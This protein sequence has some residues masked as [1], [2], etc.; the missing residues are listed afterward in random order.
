METTTPTRSEDAVLLE[1]FAADGDE[2]AF[3]ELVRRHVGLVY[4]AARRQTGG[5]AAAEDV[6]Q[7]VF[8]DLARKAGTLRERE[9]LA[10]WL[11][12]STRFA[13][14]KVRRGEQ[15]RREREAAAQLMHEINGTGDA[16]A[17]ADWARVRPAIDEAL[18]ALA[19][20]D[21]TAVLLRFF[22]GRGWAEVGATLRVSEE[23][24]RKRVERA[25]ERM[26]EALGRQG[27]T[28]TG[29]ALG[30]ALATQTAVAAPAGLAVKVSA[31]ALG[32]AGSGTM[33]A[34]AGGTAAG[35]AGAIGATWGLKVV[36]LGGAATAAGAALLWVSAAR[37]NRAARAELET[38]PV[39]RAEVDAVTAEVR[40]LRAEVDAADG[41][42]RGGL[43]L[44][45]LEAEAEEIRLERE[46]R[47]DL[48]R[49]GVVIAGRVKTQGR[50]A[51]A[52]GMTLE[53]ALLAA[54]G[55]DTMAHAK[56]IRVT[57]ALASGEVKVFTLDATQGK[58]LGFMLQAGDVIYVPEIIL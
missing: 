53:A 1:R 25:L 18:Q 21:R 52:P 20:P 36:V 24:A 49:N 41:L 14:A 7:D 6:T 35:V 58:D 40:R 27:I 2:A 10:G 42:R 32:G 34:G 50:I 4:Y 9:T 48:A 17:Q 39:Q 3:A 56:R 46:R 51:F 23:A 45:R 43:E 12:T 8:A 55:T 31:A 13:A 19:E 38:V 47:S 37:A 11:H 54:G 16:A 5:C 22:E 30:L 28:S 44:Q 29:A 57:R 15:R 33:A 26:G